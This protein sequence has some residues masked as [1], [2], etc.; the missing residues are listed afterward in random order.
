MARRSGLLAALTVLGL[1]AGTVAVPNP[2]GAGG[3]DTSLVGQMVAGAERSLGDQ[4]TS[5]VAQAYDRGYDGLQIAEGLLEGGVTADGTITE[6]EDPIEPLRAP[7]GVVAGSGTSAEAI[8]LDALERGIQK[9]TKRLDKK[10]DLTARAERMGAS[11]ADVF[12]MLVTIAATFEGYSP[13][14]IIVD[15]LMA[16]GFRISPGSKSGI[17]IVDEKGKVIPPGAMP[18]SEEAQESESFLETFVADVADV[19]A[20]V[21]PRAAAETEF[22]SRFDVT[23]DVQWGDDSTVLITAKGGV[24]VPVDKS[25]RKYWVGSATGNLEGSG[26]CSVGGGTKHPWTIDGNVVMGI[27]GRADDDALQLRFAITEANLGTTGDDSLC[28]D[29]VRDSAAALESLTL[30][31]IEV[32]VRGGKG[33]LSTSF[34]D[35]PM[36]IEVTLAS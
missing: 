33:R 22:D 10:H 21:D 4:A 12:T 13:E 24:G 11:G 2:A 18:P 9:T 23:I 30:P 31:S 17:V 28:V 6:D 26:A 8:A 5:A 15:G 35:D 14:Q 19:V 7:S 20:G 1:V 34:G 3:E 27:S 32:P 36:D 16:G 29:I 25:L